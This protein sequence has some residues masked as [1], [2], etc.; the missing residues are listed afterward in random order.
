MFFCVIIGG[1]YSNINWYHFL[2]TFKKYNIWIMLI[3]YVL[4]KILK[5]L[6]IL[7]FI[8]YRLFYTINNYIH[9]IKDWTLIYIKFNKK[10]WRLTKQFEA[11]GY[12]ENTPGVTGNGWYGVNQM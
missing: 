12:N 11:T 6:K 2:R 9:I 4:C 10:E 7:R 8:Y 3:V 5:L 1:L